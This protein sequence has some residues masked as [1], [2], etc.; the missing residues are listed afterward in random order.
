MH[1][2][3]TSHTYLRCI[4]MAGKKEVYGGY[5]CEFVGTVSDRLN[6]TICTKVL[7]DPHL[8]V[9]CGQHF[10]ET[11]LNQWFT[12]QG[13]ESCPHCRA[14]GEEFHH[15]INKGLRSEVNQL[16]IRCSN[17]GEGCQWMGELG[18]LKKH[19]ESDIG[20]G[21]VMMECP[22]KCVWLP[23][24][25]FHSTEILSMR[26]RDLADHL[27]HSCYLRP[28]QC[29]F[30]G[31]KDTYEAITGN[32]YV[33]SVRF[34]VDDYF[35]HQATCLEVPINCPNRCGSKKI[36][37][38]DMESHRS[39]CP[40][41]PVECP[42][43]KAGCK[44][45]VCRQQLEDHMNTSLQQHLML[46]LIDRGKLKMELN[47]MA[48]KLSKAE[49]ELGETKSKLHEAEERLA[50]C[51]AFSNS[52][53][54]LKSRGHSMKVIMPNFSEYRCSGKVWHSPPFYYREGYKMCLAV[55]ADEADITVS[56]V[57]LRGEFDDQ[58]KWPIECDHSVHNRKYNYDGCWHFRLCSLLQYPADNGRL[59]ID[60]QGNFCSLNNEKIVHMVND[61]LTFCVEYSDCFLRVKI[62]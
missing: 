26:R 44:M 4:K 29:E 36:K 31:L 55:Y 20:C 30:C 46:L 41:E 48:A 57:Q 24:K 9:C 51:E 32:N 33:V 13:K 60:Y 59:P 53:N 35:G 54:K 16:K 6:C 14:V 62:V 17:H 8:A 37:R 28:Y 12:R 11:C 61:C 40:Q 25:Y 2:I 7:R 23:D 43:A 5:D 47:V 39:Q 27:L 22:N 1:V 34:G 15:V 10:C 52:A 56:I 21:F 45:V 19:L 38:K 18:I 3:K 49:T 58:L 50:F 42:F